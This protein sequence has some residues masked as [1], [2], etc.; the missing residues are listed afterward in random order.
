MSLTRGLLGY[1]LA[2]GL[3]CAALWSGMRLDPQRAPG[4]LR[5]VSLWRAGQRSERHVV[6]SE[7]AALAAPC[8]AGC[9]RVIER[10]VDEGPLP[11]W[12]RATPT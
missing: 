9:T 7:A 12:P 10:V 1:A 2:L 8:S 4:E 11:S 3:G 5:I 6:D